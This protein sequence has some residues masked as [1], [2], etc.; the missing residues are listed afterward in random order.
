MKES[1][2]KQTYPRWVGVLLGLL[3]P[4]S[5]HFLSGSKS[6]GIKW[7][8]ALLVLSVVVRSVVAIPVT[9]AVVVGIFLAFLLFPLLFITMLCKSYRRIPRLR[10]KGWLALILALIFTHIIPAWLSDGIATPYKVPTDAMQ[11]TLRGITTDD[12]TEKTSW[13]DGVMA[14]KKHTVFQALEAGILENIRMVP[15]GIVCTIGNTEHRLPGYV[16]QLFQR[17][18]FYNKGDVLWEG[19]VFAGDRI[20]VEK[21]TYWFRPPRKGDI[22]VF[23][24]ENIVHPHVRN[25]T[26]YTKRIVATPGD[27]I[28]IQPPHILIDNEPLAEP[29]VFTQLSFGNAGEMAS[30]T[31]SVTL[32]EDEYF[33]LGDN[34]A[35]SLDSRYFGSIKRDSIV[36]RVSTIYWPFTRMGAVR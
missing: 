26:F 12:S 14:G 3:L 28:R 32:G 16:F 2:R 10:P 7:F 27:T 23:S 1:T 9:G 20:M 19:T 25:D 8:L 6:E 31:N 33:V 11:P 35:M 24:T 5:A 22:I 36:G 13:L 34:T 21:T 4:G 17:K 18:A 15:E 29:A 30:P